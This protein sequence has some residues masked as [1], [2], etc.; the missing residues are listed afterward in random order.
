M[1]KNKGFEVDLI[2]ENEL[3]KIVTLEIIIEKT[4][5]IAL[6]NGETKKWI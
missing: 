4:D 1:L 2:G 6:S 3:D 5:E